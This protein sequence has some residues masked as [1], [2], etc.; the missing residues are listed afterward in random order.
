M[1]WISFLLTGLLDAAERYVISVIMENVL[2]GV[3]QEIRTFHWWSLGD[4]FIVRWK[5]TYSRCSRRQLVRKINARRTW[6]SVSVNTAL[7]TISIALLRAGWVWCKTGWVPLCKTIWKSAIYGKDE[8][9]LGQ[10]QKKAMRGS[11]GVVGLSCG[12]PLQEHS[13]LKPNRIKVGRTW[14]CFLFLHWV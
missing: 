10:W 7:V 8:L 11:K 13:L 6:V 14:E 3:V 2:A 5:A 12:R 1:K 9:K 4:S